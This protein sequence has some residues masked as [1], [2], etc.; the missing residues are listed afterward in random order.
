M[1][2]SALEAMPGSA[3]GEGVIES[4]LRLPALVSSC[5][6][7][8]GIVFADVEESSERAQLGK[9]VLSESSQLSESYSS[10]AEGTGK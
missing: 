9:E 6:K 7:W 4:G 1:W 2:W 3:A 8:N 5:A 10:T